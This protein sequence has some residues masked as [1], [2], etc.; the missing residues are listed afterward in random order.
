MRTPKHLVLLLVLLAWPGGLLAQAPATERVRLP[1]Y[2]TSMRLHAMLGPVTRPRRTPAGPLAPGLE[3]PTLAGGLR[4][5]VRT[6]PL[7][8]QAGVTGVRGGVRPFLGLL[9]FPPSVRLPR[10]DPQPPGR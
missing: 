4:W 10:P 9:L 1:R 5:A 3:A 8:V 7:V 2:L 6:G